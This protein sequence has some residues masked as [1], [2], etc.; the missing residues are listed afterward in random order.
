METG[1]KNA[2]PAPVSKNGAKVSDKDITNF[3]KAIDDGIK[4]HGAP[5]KYGEAWV[6]KAGRMALVSWPPSSHG[7]PFILIKSLPVENRADYLAA[8]LRRYQIKTVDVIDSDFKTYCHYRLQ[9][10]SKACLN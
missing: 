8:V 7:Y 3:L 10:R 2:A 1:K 6:Q 5:T 9:E 4:L